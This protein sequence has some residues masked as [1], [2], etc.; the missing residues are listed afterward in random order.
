[1]IVTEILKRKGTTVITISP[2]RSIKDAVSTLVGHGVGSLLV[3]NSEEQV[4]GIITER[5]ILRASA[6]TFDNLG[7][8]TVEDLMTTDVL[9]GCHDD[10]IGYVEQIMTENRIRHLPIYRAKRLVGIISIGDVVKAI[11]EQAAGEVRH[12]TSYIT[13]QYPA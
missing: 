6:A 11:A 12:L 1:M 3:V 2:E 10:T 9:I 4:V 8:L 5:D 7:G 13:D